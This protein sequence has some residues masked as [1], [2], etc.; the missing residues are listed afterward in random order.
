[1]G[2]FLQIG[3]VASAT[4]QSADTI[5]FYERDRLLRRAARSSGGFR[6][7]SQADVADLEFIRNA[8]DLGFPLQE[9]RDFV[10]LRTTHTD[11]R[12]VERMLEQKISSVRAKIAAMRKLERELQRTMIRCQENLRRAKNGEREDCPALSEISHIRGRKSR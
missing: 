4:G 1:M 10:A 2:A 3:D 9:I 6:L 12:Q 7:F 11:C 8:Q 5:R